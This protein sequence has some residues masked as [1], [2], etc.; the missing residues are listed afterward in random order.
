MKSKIQSV[1]IPKTKSKLHAVNFPKTGFTLKQSHKWLL[2][3]NFK[4]PK[5]V[6][7]TTNFYRYRQKLPDKRYTYTTKILPNGVELVLM[8]R[9]PK[10]DDILSGGAFRNPK[11]FEYLAQKI[12]NNLT[13]DDID[14]FQT[15]QLEGG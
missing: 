14:E 4:I 2:E 9:K 8:W 10:E 6:D 1:L 11:S 13:E 7:E 5:K 3:H 15:A 12:L